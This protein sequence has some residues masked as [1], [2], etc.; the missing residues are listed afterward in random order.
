MLDFKYFSKFTN[1]KNKKLT[2]IGFLIAFQE[3]RIK[4]F[5]TIFGFG[6]FMI[7]VLNQHQSTSGTKIYTA[8]TLRKSVIALFY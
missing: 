2:D 5:L 3:T 8:T 1:F 6:F 4:V 7:N